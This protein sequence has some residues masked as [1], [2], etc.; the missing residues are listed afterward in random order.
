MV[1][2]TREPVIHLEKKLDGYFTPYR[3]YKFQ[4]LKRHKLK[5]EKIYSFRRKY[6][7][8]RK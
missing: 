6:E 4:V 3:K 2:G 8:K 5:K 1:H 7:E